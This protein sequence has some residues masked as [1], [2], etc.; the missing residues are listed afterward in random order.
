M[1]V[2]PASF[3]SIGDCCIDVYTGEGV[4]AVGGNALNVA[5]AWAAAGIDSWYLGAVGDDPH[6]ERV[7]E[8]VKATGVNTSL[9]RRLPGATGVTEIELLP[10]GDRVLVAEDFGVSA[11]YRPS[12]AELAALPSIG[13]A[14]CA[15]LGDGFRDVVATLGGLAPVSYDFSTR[16]ELDDLAG[17]EVAFYSLHGSAESARELGARAIAGGATVAVVTQGAAGSVAVH[18]GGVVQQPALTSSARD[19]CGAGDS[20]AAAFVRARVQGAELA[21]CM[22][23][24]TMAAAGTCGMLGAWPQPLPAVSEVA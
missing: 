20:Y 2:S 11:G 24:A 10:D 19:T 23:M 17:L 5:A 12:A 8:T 18:A 1:A 15:T 14:H 7:L 3:V 13:W 16:H 22:R 4:S 6:G 9:V 21:E